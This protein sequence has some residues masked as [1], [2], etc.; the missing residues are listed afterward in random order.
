MRASL[1]MY[2]LPEVKQA[3]GAWWQGLARAF[4]A[5]GIEDV[6]DRLETVASPY[7]HW[8]QPDLLFSQT[9]GYP[10]T[11]A[12]AG[13]ARLV[14]TPVYAAPGCTGAS[15]CSLVIV[16]ENNP[17]TSLEKLRGARVAYNSTDSQSGY[18]VLRAM[19]AP[20]AQGGKFFASTT[21]TGG[22]RASIAAVASSAADLCAVDC[23]THALLR[24]HAPTALAGTRVLC[25]TPSAPSLPYVT[26]GGAGD[27]LVEALRA[28]LDRALT[29]TSLA[30]ARDDLRIAGAEVLPLAAYDVML[31]MEQAAVK[32][33]YPTLI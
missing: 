16:G 10:L 2:D 30:A 3:S 11:H 14:A 5:E 32:A 13:Q 7:D 24:L 6:P 28:G 1:P 18:N 22:H 8:R 26:A 20:L 12:I 19:V 23:V 27:D 33:G 4:R 29:D 21:A 31:E 15:Y 17:A 25:T 9:C